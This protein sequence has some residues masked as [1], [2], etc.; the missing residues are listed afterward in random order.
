MI[1]IKIFLGLLVIFEVRSVVI[2]NISAPAVIESGS[3]LV[4]DCDYDY[5]EAEANQLDL[6]WYFN[7]SPTPIYQWVPAMNV[8][9]Q[10][11]DKKFKDKVD[12]TYNIEESDQFKKHRALRI[13]NPDQNY[14]GAYKCKISS[15]LDEDFGQKDVL[16]Y[17]EHILRPHVETMFLLQFRL[18]RF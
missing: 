15:F 8:G 1:C 12:L 14:S 9:P 18:L 11:V 5:Q 10:V 17:G 16:V 7:G 13:V 2:K 6:K 3:D 4:L